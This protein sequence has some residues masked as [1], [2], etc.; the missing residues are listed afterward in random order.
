MVH[1]V[2]EL[3]LLVRASQKAGMVEESEA[4]IAT[5][6]FQFADLT[7][8]ALMTPRTEL[9]GVP[10]GIE[11]EALLARAIATRRGRLLVYDGSLDNIVGVVRARELLGVVREPP[12][13]FDV[14]S[15]VRPVLAV[16]E[17][18]GADD[19]LE[20]MQRAGCHL[21]VVV[22]EY[23]GTAG[24]VTLADLMRALVGR[25]D[26]EQLLEA[27]PADRHDGE[28]GGH[29]EAV[30]QHQHEDGGD[31]ETGRQVHRAILH[32]RTPSAGPPAGRLT[33]SG[34][35]PIL[36]PPCRHRSRACASST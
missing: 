31:A 16:P 10:L 20:D 29:E 1:T 12:A 18:R 26:E 8:G 9:L 27:R 24:I 2:E 3:A 7:A 25:V 23:G 17:G 15:L 22:D 5:R 14:R 19:L 33:S 13:R 21:A 35:V 32:R 4:R 36:G 30:R 28:L 11:L 6:A 34:P